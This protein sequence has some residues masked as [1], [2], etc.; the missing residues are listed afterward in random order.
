MN[1]FLRRIF[2]GNEIVDQVVWKR[3]CEITKKNGFEFRVISTIYYGL[4]NEYRRKFSFIHD[5]LLL[6]MSFSFIKN[7][8]FP[9]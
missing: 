7:N 4:S 5:L 1:I 6:I 9:S 3:H 8:N 2:F